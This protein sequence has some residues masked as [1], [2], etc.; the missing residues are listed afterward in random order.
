[1]HKHSSHTREGFR[2]LVEQNCKFRYLLTAIPDADMEHGVN[3]VTCVTNLHIIAYYIYSQRQTVGMGH[4]PCFGNTYLRIVQLSVQLLPSLQ[5][6]NSV[7][8]TLLDLQPITHSSHFSI[9]S[10]RWCNTFV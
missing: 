2:H 4:S 5:E 6:M 8:Q 1:V 9:Y 10:K 3:T 7:I